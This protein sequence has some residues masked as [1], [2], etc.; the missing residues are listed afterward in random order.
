MCIAIIPKGGAPISIPV[1]YPELHRRPRTPLAPEI[2]FILA[3]AQKLFRDLDVSESSTQNA[4]V[5]VV[6]LRVAIKETFFVSAVVSK[7]YLD[8]VE[9]AGTPDVPL[10]VMTSPKWNLK[11]G[12]GRL[13]FFVGLKQAA[14]SMLP[15][16][17]SAKR[18]SNNIS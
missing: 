2:A 11:T 13:G 9:Q 17:R 18:K 8:S 10:E 14:E 15:K 4:S 1:F 7:S 5:R 6:V 16:A 3:C 12:N